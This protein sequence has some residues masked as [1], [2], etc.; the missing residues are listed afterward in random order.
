MFWGSFWLFEALTGGLCILLGLSFAIDDLAGGWYV[1]LVVAG[2]QVF[3]I[4][5]YWLWREPI[6]PEVR[7]AGVRSEVAV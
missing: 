4:L 1:L 5:P 6:A 2:M 3:N 7:P